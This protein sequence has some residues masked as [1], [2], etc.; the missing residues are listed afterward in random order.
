MDARF[1]IVGD[2]HA[3]PQEL[4]R[5]LSSLALQPEDHVV[6]LGDYVDRGPDARAVVEL[7]L[8]MKADAVCRMTFL[9]GNHEDMFL[10][11]LGYEGRYGEAFLVNGGSATVKSY[12]LSQTLRGKEAAA[13]LPP[14]HLE[15]Y[16]ALETVHLNGGTFCVHAGLN[17]L[18]PLEKQNEE[19]LLWI[20][21]EFIFHPHDFPF[22][23][24]FGHTPHREV[25]F[26]LPYKIG[27]DTGLVYGGKL[28]CLEV[29]ER[30]LFQIARGSRQVKETNVTNRW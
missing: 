8:S 15:F 1:F 23:V 4:E 14:A 10:D 11:F 28:S 22:T 18:R 7:L 2:I 9:K 30:K 25:F 24:V 29:T 26:D 17:P 27:I 5:L 12:G 13:L 6:F 3:C 16:R 21:Q 19:E 20:R